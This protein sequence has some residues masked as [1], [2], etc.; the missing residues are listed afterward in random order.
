MILLILMISM[1]L[2]ILMI[3]MILVLQEFLVIVCVMSKGSPEAKL[4]Q[5]FR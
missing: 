1:I 2:M 3:S 4:R 5:I